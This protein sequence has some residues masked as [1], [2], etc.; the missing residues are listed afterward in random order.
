MKVFFSFTADN[1][2]H[3]VYIFYSETEMKTWCGFVAP[4]LAEEEQNRLWTMYGNQDDAKHTVAGCSKKTDWR[5]Q[6][7]CKNCTS[8]SNNLLQFTLDYL[9]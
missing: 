5:K 4:K 3:N 6:L 7:T 2:V 1:F 9:G 8:S